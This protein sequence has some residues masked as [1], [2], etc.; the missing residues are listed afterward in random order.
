MQEQLI[1]AVDAIEGNMIQ[2]N[3]HPLF[4]R[5][6]SNGDVHDGSGLAIYGHRI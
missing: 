2:G 1:V 5:E 4:D 3:L 6:N